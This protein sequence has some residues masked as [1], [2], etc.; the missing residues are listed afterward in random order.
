MKKVILISIVL[1]FIS[2]TS[3]NEFKLSKEELKWQPYKVDDI[4]V[5]E[6]NIGEVDSIKITSIDSYLNPEDPLA[7]FPDQH[8]TLFVNG[9]L[10]NPNKDH[11]HWD[12]V[13]F[14]DLTS[15]K[16]TWITFNLSKMS[17]SLQYAEAKY[18]VDQLN[19][20]YNNE[21]VINNCIN[22]IIELKP[23]YTGGLNY[24]FDLK[25]Y[26]WSLKYGYVKYSFKNGYYRKLKKFIR[27]GK[28]IL[29]DCE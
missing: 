3:C 24:E 1:F 6:S 11:K 13:N 22:D 7:I 25:S 4:L 26:S 20:F 8:E 14:L 15:S 19:K 17:D 10:L 28:D 21:K 2:F 27:N 16:E 29:P 18:S 12:H 5:F 23:N 9:E